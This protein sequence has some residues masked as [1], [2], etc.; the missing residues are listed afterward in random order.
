MVTCPTCSEEFETE[1][2]VKKHHYYKHNES[3]AKEHTE[4]VECG[5]EFEYY[6]SE[7]TGYY[8]S[9]CSDNSWGNENLLHATGD[10]NPRWRG[11]PVETSCSW[12][13]KEI[14][15]KITNYENYDNNFCS[16]ECEGKF[17]EVDFSGSGNPRYID[18]NSRQRKYGT[19]WRRERDKA[20]KRDDYKCVFCG[21]GEEE[22]ERNPAVHHKQPVRNFENPTDAH[23]LDNLVCLCPK[24]HQMAEAGNIDV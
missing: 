4:C 23:Y 8:C 10:E 2:G 13:K 3:I 17:R 21:K 18:G 12:C 15:V 14:I 5:S 22:L 16:K 6:P 9:E 7:K 19:G 20:L 24:H 1:G 11:G